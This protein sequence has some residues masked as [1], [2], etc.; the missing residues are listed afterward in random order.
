MW[1]ISYLIF[2]FKSTAELCLPRAKYWGISSYTGCEVLRKGSARTK[3]VSR[4][5]VVFV[6]FKAA[7]DSIHL[8]SMWR[9]L[10]DYGIPDKYTRLIRCLYDNC[11]AAILVEGEITDLFRI[12]WC[13]TG[14]CLVPT[15][16]CHN[17]RCCSSQEL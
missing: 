9:I 15:A 6:D 14:M 11:E 8:P 1:Q 7:F 10:S 16:F 4:V 2:T 3:G 5:G 13:S 12:V 17:D